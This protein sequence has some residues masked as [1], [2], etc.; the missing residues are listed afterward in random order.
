MSNNEYNG[1]KALEQ[2]I[3][4]N[5]KDSDFNSVGNKLKENKNTF[6]FIGNLISLYLPEVLTVLTK[7]IGGSRNN[8]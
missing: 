1:F 7:F 2:E 6:D 5:R 8:K 4:N 3:I